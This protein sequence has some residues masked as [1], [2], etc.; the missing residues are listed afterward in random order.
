MLTFYRRLL[1]FYNLTDYLSGLEGFICQPFAQKVTR[2]CQ[3]GLRQFQPCYV[4]LPFVN[5][6]RVALTITAVTCIWL[7]YFAREKKNL[8]IRAKIYYSSTTV[9]PA[10]GQLWYFHS[11]Q[12]RLHVVTH[13]SSRSRQLACFPFIS[14]EHLVMFSL[15]LIGRCPN[16][17]QRAEKNITGVQGFVLRKIHLQSCR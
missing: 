8:K 2:I 4:I 17:L 15:A 14:H 16:A 11:L 7:G 10:C 12:S 3:Q 9:W 5:A 1:T 6:K 13:V